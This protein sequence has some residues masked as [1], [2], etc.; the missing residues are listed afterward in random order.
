[1]SSVFENRQT[2]C[3]HLWRTWQKIQFGPKDQRL[4]AHKGRRKNDHRFYH[5]H[6][7][8]N[9]HTRTH[10][11]FL[12]QPRARTT[13]HVSRRPNSGVD[14][15]PYI[16]FVLLNFIIYVSK[17]SH[18]DEI[19]VCVYVCSNVICICTHTRTYTRRAC[20]LRPCVRVLRYHG[21][22]I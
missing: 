16:Y 19:G 5:L 6:S 13:G 4:F 17:R 18:R 21:P 20:S 22:L 10:F 7:L 15:C 14:F 2:R 12:I 1:M 11:F 8:T 3:A 9:T